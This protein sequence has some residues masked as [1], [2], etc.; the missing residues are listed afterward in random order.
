MLWHG[1]RAGWE[2]L[3]RGTLTPGQPVVLTSV[4]GATSHLS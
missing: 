1:T 4:S 3:P 2:T